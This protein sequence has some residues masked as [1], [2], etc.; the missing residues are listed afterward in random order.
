MTI[1]LLID[2]GGHFGDEIGVLFTE[3]LFEILKPI[4]CAI[5]IDLV[6]E[7][8]CHFYFVQL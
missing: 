6:Y 3:Q 8:V 5:E 4:D 1:Y 2:D 7:V